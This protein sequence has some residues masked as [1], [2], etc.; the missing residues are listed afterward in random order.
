MNKEIVVSL[1]IIVY[2]IIMI[3]LF[4]NSKIVENNQCHYETLQAVTCE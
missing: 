2:V 1:M 3:N 4:L